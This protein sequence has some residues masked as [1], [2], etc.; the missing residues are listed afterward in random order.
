MLRVNRAGA[1]LILGLGLC[2]SHSVVPQSAMAQS[3]NLA[4][5]C[6]SSYQ[7]YLAADGPKAFASARNGPCGWQKLTE[8]FP[9]FAAVQR[10]AITQCSI[11]GGEQCKVVHQVK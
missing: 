3:P 8:R 9:N 10:Q 11:N 5:A 2:A 1:G 4:P 7:R 6:Q